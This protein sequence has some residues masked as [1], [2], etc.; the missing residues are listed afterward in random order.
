MLFSIV[1]IN[2][3][4][5]AG[6]QKTVESVLHQ[7]CQDFQYIIIDGDSND[8]SIN[9]LKKINYKNFDIV[10]EKDHGIYDAMN[11]GIQLSTGDYII[12]LNSGDFFPRDSVLQ[13]IKNFINESKNKIDFIYGDAYE[14]SPRKEKF[15]L[16]ISKSHLSAWYGMFAHHQS[17]VYSNE[18]IKKYNIRYDLSYNLASDW[19][20]TLR[21]MNYCKNIKKVN[22]PLS[23]FEQGGYS[24]KFII[25][26]NE[27]YKIRLKTLKF[28]P[29]KSATIYCYHFLLNSVRKAFPYIYND[30]RMSAIDKL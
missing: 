15:Y 18:I 5:L 4:N 6:L 21:F 20:F 11:K 2:Y 10:S 17:M 9:Y 1:T 26:L 16:K 14:Y 23:V 8:G 19:D 3:N 29:I 7:T 30:V 25:G 13:N 12:F 27:Q 24:D 22:F 28:S